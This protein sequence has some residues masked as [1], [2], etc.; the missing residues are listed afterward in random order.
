VHDH[1]GCA[2]EITKH[3]HEVGTYMEPSQFDSAIR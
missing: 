3:C 1:P 2:A